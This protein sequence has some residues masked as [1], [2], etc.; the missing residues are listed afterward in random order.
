MSQWTSII[1][2]I[3][4]EEWPAFWDEVLVEQE[5]RRTI[6]TSQAVADAAAQAYAAAVADRPAKDAKDMDATAVVGPGEHVVID[7]V[8]WVNN[9][10]TWLSPLTAGPKDYPMGWRTAKPEDLPDADAWTI[11]K[12]YK[13]GDVV[14]FGGRAWKCLQKHTAQAGW[15]PVAVPAL[16]AQA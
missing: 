13:P 6:R 10:A 7:G 4:D 2:S 14:T 9:T 1:T 8:E 12:E 15:D 5:A 16:W 11:G 3:S